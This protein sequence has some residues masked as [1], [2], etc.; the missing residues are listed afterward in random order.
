MT[1]VELNSRWCVIPWCYAPLWGLIS[2]SVLIVDETEMLTFLG[3]VNLV[4][5]AVFKQTRLG[6]HSLHPIS[7]CV[8]WT[9]ACTI[10]YS[11]LCCWK[12]TQRWQS[13][14]LLLPQSVCE[15][16]RAKC[17]QG[18]FPGRKTFFPSFFFWG[19]GMEGGEDGRVEGEGSES[20]LNWNMASLAF[21]PIWSTKDA[22]NCV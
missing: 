21:L 9:T 6:L 13:G 2:G 3:T 18:G 12:E 4:A 20:C 1:Q 16:E 19:G 5:S 22:Y 11:L 10:L 14:F 17:L 8:N 15:P 7:Q